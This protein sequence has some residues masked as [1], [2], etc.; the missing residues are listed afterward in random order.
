MTW[1]SAHTVGDPK[2]MWAGVLIARAGGAAI[3]L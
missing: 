2:R 1:N 3:L